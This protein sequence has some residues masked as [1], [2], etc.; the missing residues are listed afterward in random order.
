MHRLRTVV[1]KSHCL[2]FVHARLMAASNKGDSQAV[3]SSPAMG[4]KE[5]IKPPVLFSS[6][7]DSLARS[8]TNNFLQ[9][10]PKI[11]WHRNSKVFALVGVLSLGIYQGD[12]VACKVEVYNCNGRLI[13]P[14]ARPQHYFKYNPHPGSLVPKSN[15]D[16][17]DLLIAQGFL[18]PLSSN[19]NNQTLKWI[20][21]GKVA[22]YRFI[23]NKTEEFK[24]HPGRVMPRYPAPDL[25]RCTPCQEL[26]S[27]SILHLSRELD[28]SGNQKPIDGAPRYLSST[29]TLFASTSVTGSEI[30]WNPGRE[31]R[32]PSNIGPA[33]L[34]IKGFA[35]GQSFRLVRVSGAI[36]PESSTGCPPLPVKPA[37][38]QIPIRGPTH[39]TNKGHEPK[40][41]M[42]SCDSSRFS[43]AE[44]GSYRG[45]S[46][47]LLRHNPTITQRGKSFHRK[48]A[49][50]HTGVSHSGL[51]HNV[52]SI[53]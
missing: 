12:A 26:L 15:A 22:P 49:E 14:A 45:T 2:A 9:H 47:Q 37:L 41:L 50:S 8:A 24:F 18:S 3:G 1:H 44:D 35:L 30:G 48:N 23:H 5:P 51:I 13:E 10:G 21:V 29:Q 52:E 28:A 42:D 34:L 4:F 6:K 31:S 32:S 11:R 38:N 33:F 19:R 53:I 39:L 20:V 25:F 17:G 16:L 36:A 46:E 7:F 43:V 40:S 27:V